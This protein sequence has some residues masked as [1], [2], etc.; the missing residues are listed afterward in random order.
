QP[1]RAAGVPQCPGGGA[2]SAD[3][4]DVSGAWL[5]GDR[6]E[7]DPHHEHHPPGSAGR[8]METP[9]R[10]G[11][12]PV[13]RSSWPLIA[14][15]SA[16]LRRGSVAARVRSRRLTRDGDGDRYASVRVEMG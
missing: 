7:P 14:R 13:T 4:A 9:I 16:A 8:T 15:S 11:A 6:A 2:Q 3:P 12:G 5:Q 10:S 1:A